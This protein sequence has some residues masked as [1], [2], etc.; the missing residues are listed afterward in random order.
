MW[1][2]NVCD[3]Y[4]CLCGVCVWCVCLRFLFVLSV[5]FVYVCHVYLSLFGVCVR[6]CIVV[7]MCLWLCMWVVVCVCVG[8]FLCMVYMR[9]YMYFDYVYY[10]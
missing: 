8:E 6:V 7:C 4:M 2:V 5:C 9:I 10:V 1:C 3:V